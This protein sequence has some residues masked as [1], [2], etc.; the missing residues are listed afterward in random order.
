MLVLRV[1]H[2]FE[3]NHF[4]SVKSWGIQ[5]SY[6]SLTLELWHSKNPFWGL[7][8]FYTRSQGVAA[9]VSA[10]AAETRT[11]SSHGWQQWP[12]ACSV[13]QL[14]L[15]LQNLLQ[16]LQL[17]GHHNL[18]HLSFE[19]HGRALPWSWYWVEKIQRFLPSLLLFV[20]QSVTLSDVRSTCQEVTRP[21]NVIS[22]GWLKKKV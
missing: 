9:L 11:L 17:T 13:F 1:F 22:S 8:I 16:G 21:C 3:W 14:M 5:D 4:L 6:G 15:F 10:S 20:G 18:L 12:S 2:W 7:Y 19:K